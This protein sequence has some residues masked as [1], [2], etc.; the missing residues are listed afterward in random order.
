MN[1]IRHAYLELVPGL[2]AYF[3][4]SR[5]DDVAGIMVSSGAEP[6]V[7]PRIGQPTAAAA[8]GGL[9]HGLVTTLGVIAV[10]NC[11]V[12]GVFLGLV[13]AALGGDV[14]LAIA[15]GV[16]GFVILFAG[17]TIWGLL[18]FKHGA[19]RLVCSVPDT[20]R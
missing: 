16:V 18:S 11:V 10:I 19:E 6:E 3:I 4:T 13:V 14:A 2:E 7:A 5:Y 12:V 15:I 17:Q 1:R 9:I 20:A 8:L